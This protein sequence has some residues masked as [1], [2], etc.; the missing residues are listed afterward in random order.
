MDPISLA[1]GAIAAL[2]VALVFS[3][4]MVKRTKEAVMAEAESR[5]ALLA[6]QLDQV[7]AT[8]RELTNELATTR[9]RLSE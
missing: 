1:A 7:D 2:V 6:A 3:V 9:N 8:R 4:L 5:T